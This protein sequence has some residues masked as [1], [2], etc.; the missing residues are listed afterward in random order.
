MI[1]TE[2]NDDGGTERQV[3][4]RRN[5]YTGGKPTIRIIHECLMVRAAMLDWTRG[6]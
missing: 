2:N 5:R 1:K 3:C 6:S 4:G